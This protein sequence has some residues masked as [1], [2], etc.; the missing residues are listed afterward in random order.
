M[1]IFRER[2]NLAA[3]RLRRDTY[4]LSRLY[5]A[6]CDQDLRH[7]GQQVFKSITRRAE[8]NNAQF[9]VPQVLLMFE[10]LVSGH[11]DGEPGRFRFSEQ[12]TVLQPSP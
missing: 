1:K 4:N 3:I 12:N 7:Q 2:T 8:H 6:D 5:P 9:S 10:V 11:E